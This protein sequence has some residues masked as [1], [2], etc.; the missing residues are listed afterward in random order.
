MI[1]AI[2]E[3]TIGMTTLSSTPD[4]LTVA[5]AA[6]AAPTSPPIRACEDDEGRP[7]HQVSRFQPMAPISAAAQIAR[8][9]LP[10]GASMMPLPTV[11]ATWPNFQTA[12]PPIRLAIAAMIKAIR[13]V[14]ARV[15]TEVA[16]ALAAS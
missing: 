12:R 14:R 1:P 8:P 15:E 11:A 2:G 4:H 9:S 13:G 7:Y 5:P 3:R 6:S 10:E 16:I